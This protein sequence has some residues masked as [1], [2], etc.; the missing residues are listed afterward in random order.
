[1]M[2]KTQA[3]LSFNYDFRTRPGDSSALNRNTDELTVK[4]PIPICPRVWDRSELARIREPNPE[5]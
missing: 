2:P 3:P 5:N 4:E 1:M